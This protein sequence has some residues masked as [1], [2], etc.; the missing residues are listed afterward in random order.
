LKKYIGISGIFGKAACV[1]VALLALSCAKEAPKRI[2][3]DV[4]FGNP[5]KTMPGISPD[6]KRLAYVAP[7]NGV[8]NIWVKTIGRTDDRAITRDADRG[9]GKYFWAYDNRHILYFQD[10]MGTDNWRLYGI[11]VDSGE[12]SDF[13]PFD[14]VKVAVVAYLKKLPREFIIQMNKENREFADAYRLDIE[15]GALSMAA[16]NPG[17]VLRWVA[18]NDLVVRGAVASG[19]QGGS[20]LIVRRSESS[21]WTTI[22]S[23]NAEDR[24]SSGALRFTRDGTGMYCFDARGLTRADSSRWISPTVP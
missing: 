4:L 1:A 10:L 2:P 3:I 22:C 20:D 14:S 11:D 18:D 7:Y 24:M 8:L 13:T 21:P 23:W 17:N 9:I 15:T 6:A 19:S 16:K 5:A 12:I